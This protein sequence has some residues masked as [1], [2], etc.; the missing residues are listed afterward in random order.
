MDASE[1]TN[2]ATSTSPKHAGN[3][4]IEAETLKSTPTCKPMTFQPRIGVESMIKVNKHDQTQTAPRADDKQSHERTRLRPEKDTRV[5]SPAQPLRRSGKKQL[6]A[7][8]SEDQPSSVATIL[9]RQTPGHSCGTVQ[10]PAAPRRHG[11]DPVAA[12]RKD[13]T[14]SEGL[15]PPSASRPDGFSETWRGSVCTRSKKT[16][17]LWRAKA[18]TRSAM[19]QRFRRCICQVTSVPTGLHSR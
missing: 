16:E 17:T 4:R 12:S 5:A 9:R 7:L 1:E 18:Y 8:R 3:Q 15:I 19:D 13:Q 2:F 11:D 14:A 10:A 6:T